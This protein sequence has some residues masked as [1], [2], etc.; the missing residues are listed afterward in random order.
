MRDFP[1]VIRAYTERGADE[2]D[3][4][5]PLRFLWWMVRQNGDQ[6]QLIV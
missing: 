6:A 5:S 1:P 3:T 2:P 4:R